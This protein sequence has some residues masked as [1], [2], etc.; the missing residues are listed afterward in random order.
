MVGRFW[1]GS[2]VQQESDDFGGRE[3]ADGIATECGAVSRA[4]QMEQR[5]TISAAGIE[6][7]Q[8]VKWLSQSVILQAVECRLDLG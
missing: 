3:T 5:V 1:I 4:G 8:I 6:P 7:D 2:H